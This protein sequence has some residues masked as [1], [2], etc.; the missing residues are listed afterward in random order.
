MAESVANTDL[1]RT[2][3]WLLR[4]GDIAWLTLAAANL[5]ASIIESE[6]LGTARRWALITCG[7]G[8]F[9]TFVNASGILPIERI[10]YG[11]ALGQKLGRVPF[12]VMLIWFVAVVGARETVRW[13]SPKSSHVPASLAAGLL[14][15]LTGV[16]LEPLAA[17]LRGFWFWAARDPSLPP[18]FVPP[19][20]SYI[21]WMGCGALLAYLLREDRAAIDRSSRPR[22][23]VIIFL[24]LN[25]VFIAA[26]LGR[27]IRG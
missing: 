19:L 4:I 7:G 1:R 25:A 5:H 9:A 15:L 3:E 2:L 14:V 24:L 17:R 20:S 11:S 6:G 27:I 13:I 22:R 10:V 23:P 12:G 16:N 21:L 26:H 18:V 8:L